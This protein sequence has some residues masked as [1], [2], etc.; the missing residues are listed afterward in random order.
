MYNSLTLIG[1]TTDKPDVK[2][3]E[4]GITVGH[5]TLA[6]YR[7]Y[8]NSNGEFDVDFIPCVMWNSVAQSA[9]EYVKKGSL[10][11]VKAYLITKEE[12]ITC[13]N[14]E[15]QP[16]SRKIRG[17]DITVEKIIYLKL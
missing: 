1:R 8:R 10:I 6:V 13:L 16:F 15:G 17:F 9:E 2:T 4:S 11:C 12:T 3:L 14:D 5:L 7:P